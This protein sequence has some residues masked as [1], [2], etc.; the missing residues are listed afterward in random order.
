V[1]RQ[2]L[3]GVPCIDDAIEGDCHAVSA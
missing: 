2:V 3:D 1:L